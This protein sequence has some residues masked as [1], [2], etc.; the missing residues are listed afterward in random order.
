M[1]AANSEWSGLPRLRIGINGRFLVAKQTGVQRAAY[2]LLL[3]LLEFDQHNTY[4]IFTGESQRGKSVWVRE[5]IE[6]VYSDIKSGENLKNH[7]W[8]QFILPR[9]AAKSSVD[10]L[11]S[12]ANMA[13]ILYKGKSIVNIHDLCF[14]VNPQWYTFAFRSLYSILI[15]RIARASNRVITNSNNS[16]NDLFQF[17]RV[18]PN[19]VNLIYWAVDK[20]FLKPDFSPTDPLP[21]DDFILYVGSVEP[22]KNI[23]NLV[24]A[25]EKFREMHPNCKTKLCLVGGENPVFSSVNLKPK[26]FG[27]DIK[28][29]GFVDDRQLRSYYRAA[30]CVVY[31][32]LYE[33]FGLPPLEAMACGAPV[34]TSCT[35]SLPEVVGD[36]A[37]LVNPLDVLQMSEAIAKVIFDP[38]LRRI[39]VE[40]GKERVQHFSWSRVARNTLAVYYD[41][42][43]KGSDDERSRQTISKEIWKYWKAREQNVT[44]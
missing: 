26:R 3:S 13:P 35:S 37:L 8:E 11:H 31:P 9:L 24:K 36:A 17:C 16:R 27:S 21:I 34:I 23:S 14:I 19:K 20:S 15:P 10:I 43:R 44:I 2:N 32:S 7:F 42:A 6:M 38:G 5:N 41:V 4:I 28:M 25:Y 39:M 29:L 40:K 1:N 18:N 33:G 30:K 12:P 22:R